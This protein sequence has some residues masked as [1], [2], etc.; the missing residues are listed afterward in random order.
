MVDTYE[1]HAVSR[2]AFRCLNRLAVTGNRQIHLLTWSVKS[3][4]LFGADLAFAEEA[5]CW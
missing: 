4:L 3:W 5:P 2:S 1:G